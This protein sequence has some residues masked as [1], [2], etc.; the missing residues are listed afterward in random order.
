ME[1]EYRY[2]L[3][4]SDLDPGE[5]PYGL[6]RAWGSDSGLPLE[7]FFSPR[8][9]WEKSTILSRISHGSMNRDAERIEEREV[10]LYVEV[11]TRRFKAQM[12]G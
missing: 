5:N 4:V 8:L 7:E 12:K 1:R 3:I 10:E 2:Y 9:V 6:V 11:L